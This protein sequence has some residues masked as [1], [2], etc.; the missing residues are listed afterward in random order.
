M[1]IN[2]TYNTVLLGSLI[3][4]I[5]LYSRLVVSYLYCLELV[6]EARSKMVATIAMTLNAMCSSLVALY[7]MFGAKDAEFLV[8]LSIYI[9]AFSLV[10][11]PFVPESPK[12]LFEKEEYENCRKALRTIA[13]WNGTTLSDEKF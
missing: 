11:C 10:F 12:L 3:N 1:Y 6:D 4:G 5:G 9:A 2:P 8:L 7:Y 13:K